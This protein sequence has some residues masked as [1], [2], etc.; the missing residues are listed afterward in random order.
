MGTESWSK[1]L[2]LCKFK[3]FIKIKESTLKKKKKIILDKLYSRDDNG[4]INGSTAFNFDKNYVVL[5]E[6]HYTSETKLSRYIDFNIMLLGEYKVLIKRKI[7]RV[8]VHTKLPTVQGY[9]SVL[10]KKVLGKIVYFLNIW[11]LY[12]SVQNLWLGKKEIE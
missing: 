5:L 11:T 1:Y 9:N 3:S 12:A 8:N 6:G 10:R 2:Y 7:D 4:K